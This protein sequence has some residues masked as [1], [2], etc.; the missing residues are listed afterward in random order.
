MN[1]A[2][3]FIRNL[4]IKRRQAVPITFCIA[5]SQILWRVQQIQLA[6][7]VRVYYVNNRLYQRQPILIRKSVNV[8]INNS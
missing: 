3:L 6:P 1:G 4:F 2:V 7:F 8:N 5:S